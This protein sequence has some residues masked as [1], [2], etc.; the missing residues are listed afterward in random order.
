[1][2]LVLTEKNSEADVDSYRLSKVVQVVRRRTPPSRSVKGLGFHAR[3]RF[4]RW[5]QWLRRVPGLPGEVAAR[6]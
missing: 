3:I 1:M 4:E 2:F 6:S 5:S